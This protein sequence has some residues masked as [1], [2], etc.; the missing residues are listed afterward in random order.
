MNLK[1][2]IIEIDEERCNGCGNCVADCAEGAIAIIDGKARVISDSFCD[3]LGACIGRCPTDA[4]RI[5]QREAPPF[6]EAAA[7]AQLATLKT[8]ERKNGVAPSPHAAPSLHALTP[9]LGA[10][11][12]RGTC[13][14]TRPGSGPGWTP[15][16]AP[17]PVK[18]RLVAP[19]APFLHGADLLIAADCAAPVTPQFQELLGSKALLICCPKFEDTAATV[20]KLTAIFRQADLRSCTVLRMEVP[21][22]GGLV[23]AVRTAH[24]ASGTACRLEER[25]LSRG[26]VDMTA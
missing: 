3:G 12:L 26:G 18:L 16:A 6:D 1:P 11:P 24:Q 25:V 7:L 17:W 9:Q 22:C 8:D 4:L 15:G 5:I 23:R 2:R 10:S 13:P 19:D 14:G 21:C 20:D